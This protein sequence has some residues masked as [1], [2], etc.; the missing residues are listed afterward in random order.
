M[1]RQRLLQ[2]LFGH[3]EDVAEATRILDMEVNSFL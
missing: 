2:S 3:F 1:P